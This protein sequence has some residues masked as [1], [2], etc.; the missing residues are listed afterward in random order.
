MKKFNSL[1]LFFVLK[2]EVGASKSAKFV[3]MLATKPEDPSSIPLAPLGKEKTDCH[4]LSSLPLHTG[5]STG[6]RH[7]HK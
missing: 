6:T 2:V 1:T 4:K 3:R 5:R 7:P